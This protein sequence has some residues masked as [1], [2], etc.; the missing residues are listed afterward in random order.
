VARQP[1]GPPAY[2][3]VANDIRLRITTGDLNPGDQLPVESDL[4]DIY[5]VSRGTLRE[6]LRLLASEGLLET[7]RGR[8]GGTFVTQILP[9]DISRLLNDVL[10]LTVQGESLS[11]S[12]LAEVRSLIEP[13]AA[14]LA[15]GR[16]KYSS[17]GKLHDYLNP[18]TQA[19]Q[20]EFNWQ[21]HREVMRL[22]DNPL[23]VALFDPVFHQ[24]RGRF[25]RSQ[26]KK[27]TWDHILQ[28]HL[29]ITQLIE[30]GD[31]V[32]VQIAMAKH[33]GYVHSTYLSLDKSAN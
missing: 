33:L 31:V 3:R 13:P 22:T 15:A 1:A 16:A 10:G 29:E 25:D 24:L 9:E 19:E 14:A 28:E 32:G 12:H 23:I 21:W 26:E 5:Q 11:I 8:T 20:Y 17:A 18:T 4:V 7:I 30:A 27:A 2:D 6:A